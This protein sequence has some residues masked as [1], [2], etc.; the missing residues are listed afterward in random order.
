MPA[1][2]WLIPLAALAIL[3]CGARTDQAPRA[4]RLIHESSPYLLLHAHNPVDW[5]PW[6]D[7]AFEKARK[8]NKPIF[9]SIGYSTCYWCHVMEREI[10]SN[11]SIAALMNQ[12]FVSVKVDR[13]ERPE[14]DEVYMTASQIL[15]GDGGWPNSLFLTPDLKPFFAGTYFPPV[16]RQG[17]PGFPT[18]LRQM[19]SAWMDH[20][21]EVV[22]QA[23]R[24]AGAIRATLARQRTPAA[25][26]PGPAVAEQAVSELEGRYDPQFGG[27]GG[28]PKFPS[29]GELWLLWDAGERG[30]AKARSMV[31]GTLGA[32][33]RGAIYDQLDGGFHRYTLDRE[34]RVP[35]FEKMLYDNA[36][37]AEL[38]AVTGKATGDP[39]LQRMARGTLD[40]VLSRMTLPEGAFKSA[41]DAETDGEEGAYSTWT[42]PE[43]RKVLGADGFTKTAP[44]FGFNAPP[45]LPGGRRTLYLTQPLGK[46]AESL[47]PELDKLRAARRTRKMP[48]VDDK[49]LTDWNGMMI[50]ALARGGALLGEPR[51]TKAAERA[52]DF[53]LIR[54][55]GKDGTLLHAWRQGSAKIPAF[56]DDYAW[57]IRGLLALHETTGDARWLREAERLADEMERR[58][59]DPQGGYLLSEAKP[60]LLFQPKKVADSAVPSGNAVAVLDLLDLAKRTGKPV[61]RERAGQALR[62]FAPEMAQAPA[63]MPALALAVLR[64]DSSRLI[65]ISARLLQ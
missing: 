37:L 65:G 23:E 1:M 20:R 54:L 47:R 6:G 7:E 50:A 24:L 16:D 34:W 57:L 19:H 61:Y 10:F 32:M 40:F 30:D 41:L 52:A 14:I 39:D 45:N 9:L 31:L 60:S 43:L 38:L 28:P 13:E 63:A 56:L 22:G 55:K 5:Y 4:N 49:A 11:A 26:V 25:E 48:R 33:G 21:P 18:V 58:L 17:Q 27:F 42:D 46:Q 35:H 2:R 3:S 12:W 29:P 53:V 51:Y 62:A 8:E 44:L 15:N 59:R 36:L 64:F